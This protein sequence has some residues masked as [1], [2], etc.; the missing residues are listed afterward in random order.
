MA[1]AELQGRAAI[2]V[3][4]R[5]LCEGIP[6]LQLSLRPDS[7]R[8]HKILVG[9]ASD[10]DLIVN[11]AEQSSKSVLQHVQH[12][13]VIDK[14]D[15]LEFDALVSIHRLF[16]FE[17]TAVEQLLESLVCIVDAELFKAV[18]FK[19]LKAKNVQKADKLVSFASKRQVNLL[20]LRFIARNHPHNPVEQSR[21]QLLGQRVAVLNGFTTTQRNDRDSDSVS[22]LHGDSARADGFF[23]RVGRDLEESRRLRQHIFIRNA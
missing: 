2:S 3:E 15:V 19:D 10:F 13:A 4:A 21:I 18:L 14:V 7:H 8:L 12:F 5:V 9:S 20:H 16:L 22:L 6:N 23:Q 17:R 1:N 11:G